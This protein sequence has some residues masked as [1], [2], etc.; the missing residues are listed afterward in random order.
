ML[1]MMYIG[2]QVIM[3]T[4]P[5]SMALCSVRNIRSTGHLL[6]SSQSDFYELRLL[7]G[8]SRMH[9]WSVLLASPEPGHPW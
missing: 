8:F 2:G 6:W 7:P 9:D 1:S 4:S 5:Y 3:G